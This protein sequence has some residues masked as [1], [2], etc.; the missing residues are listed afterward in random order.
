MHPPPG[1]VFSTRCP[2]VI[3][4]CRE[5]VPEWREVVKDHWVA[6]IRV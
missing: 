2:I 1:C 6:C 4:D 5:T 3:D